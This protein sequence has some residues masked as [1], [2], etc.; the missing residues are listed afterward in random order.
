M[1]DWKLTVD[2][3]LSPLMPMGTPCRMPAPAASLA[4]MMLTDADLQSFAAAYEE[5][6][7]ETISL[8]EAGDMARRILALIELLASDPG[9]NTDLQVP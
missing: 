6:F 3:Q 1:R 9:P 4:D 5:D 8:A 7:G 2:G